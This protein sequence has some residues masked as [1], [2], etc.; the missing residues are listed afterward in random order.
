M[1]QRRLAALYREGK[2]KRSTQVTPYFYYLTEPKEPLKRI[3]INWARIWLERHC[4]SWER[5]TFDYLANRCTVTNTVMGSSKEFF[6]NDGKFKLP[7]DN[8][9]RI[10]DDFINKVRSELVCVK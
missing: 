1:A 5:I 4:K 2:I 7:G 8:V 9:I 3:G 10:T 6:I